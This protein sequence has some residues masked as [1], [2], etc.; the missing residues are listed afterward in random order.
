MLVSALALVG[1]VAVGVW[2][3]PGSLEW[4]RVKLTPGKIWLALWPLLAGGALAAAGH[5]LRRLWAAEP[6]RWVPPGDIGV[7]LGN[8]ATRVARDRRPAGP[9]EDGHKYS[10]EASEGEPQPSPAALLIGQTL[11]RWD[12]SLASWGAAGIALVIALGTLGW[13]LSR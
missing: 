3:L 9:P 1:A 7:L 8:L 5:R 11:T 6:S 4:L 13:L 10:D 12:R 2:L